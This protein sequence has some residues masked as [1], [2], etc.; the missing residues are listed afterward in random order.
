MMVRRCLGYTIKGSERFLSSMFTIS[1]MSVFPKFF[2]LVT[3]FLQIDRVGCQ[4]TQGRHI[5]WFTKFI[6][7]SAAEEWG[8][9]QTLTRVISILAPASAFFLSHLTN[10]TKVSARSRWLHLSPTSEALWKLIEQGSESRKTG[11]SR[12]MTSAS[13]TIRNIF[14][15]FGEPVSILP[16][17]VCVNFVGGKL[18]KFSVFFFFHL[19]PSF[20]AYILRL[21]IASLSIVHIF[22]LENFYVDF[23]NHKI[24]AWNL[25]FKTHLVRKTQELYYPVKVHK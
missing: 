20:P 8:Y 18:G 2:I 15:P 11:F 24:A 22:P 16:T 12:H 5:A 1:W 21:G 10:E 4:T 23:A 25:K 13:C 19:A 7:F 14:T 9:R 17:R 6:I 3:I